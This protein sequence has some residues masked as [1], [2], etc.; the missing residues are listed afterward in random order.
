M[1]GWQFNR[2]G[3][4]ASV[5]NNTGSEVFLTNGAGDSGFHPVAGPLGAALTDG[6]VVDVFVGMR[7]PSSD[8]TALLFP[9][10]NGSAFVGAIQ[11]GGAGAEATYPD[12]AYFTDTGSEII[13]ATRNDLYL[14]WAT[15]TKL[16]AIAEGIDTTGI[17][18]SGRQ[19]SLFYYP[20]AGFSLN[21]DIFCIIC[22]ERSVAA[23]NR[24]DIISYIQ[25]KF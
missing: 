13:G 8:V 4:N 10:V 14:A 1:N 24:A 18:L 23:A 7:M 19:P 5:F 16:V 25:G 11:S 15:N 3:A 20:G 6:T 17:T 22:V 21:A 9:T 12:A 2:V